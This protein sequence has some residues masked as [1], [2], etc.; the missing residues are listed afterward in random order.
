MYSWGIPAFSKQYTYQSI[1]KVYVREKKAIQFGYD[2]SVFWVLVGL[3]AS[4]LRNLFTNQVMS[5]LRFKGI[6]FS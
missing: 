3:I 6:E 4:K 5:M 2:I 1:S